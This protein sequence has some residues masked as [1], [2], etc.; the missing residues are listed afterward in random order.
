MTCLSGI[1]F[2]L[3]L[4][5]RKQYFLIDE[6]QLINAGGMLSL[7]Y[8]FSVFHEIT[9]PGSGGEKNNWWELCTRSMDQAENISNHW[10]VSI[11]YIEKPPVLHSQWG[12]LAAAAAAAA[13]SLQSCPTLC[14]P[15]DA[16]LQ[17]STI[18]GILQ[19][20]TLEWVAISF[21][22]AWKWKVKVK[23][24][25]G[26]RLSGPMDCSLPGSSVPGV[27][28]AR[29]LEWVAI[30]FSGGFPEVWLLLI[31]KQPGDFPSGSVAETPC[32]QCRGLGSIPGQGTRSWK[33]QPRVSMP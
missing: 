24:L 20:S 2:S 25:S 23:S 10:P 16:S 29:V 27:F 15:V 5:N 4:P 7:I 14:Y 18:P 12:F 13:K 6:I 19:A 1:N 11:S 9:D 8:H 22:N 31:G 21:S 3:G 17:G 28:Q 32:S 33:P 30:A 26:D